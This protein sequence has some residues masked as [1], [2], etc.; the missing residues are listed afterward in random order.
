[1]KRK[2]NMLNPKLIIASLIIFIPIAFLLN[3]FNSSI[4]AQDR[5]H[6]I[7]LIHDANTNAD[8]SHIDVTNVTDMSKIFYNS[9]FNGYIA[10]WDVSSVTNM[11]EM[12]YNSKFNGDISNWDVSSVTNMSEMFYNSSF[13]GDISNSTIGAWVTNM[14]RMFYRARAKFNSDISNW[15]VSSVTDMSVMF[16]SSKFNGDISN[17]DVSSVTDMS[18]MFGSSKFNGDISNWNVSSVTN[19]SHMFNRSEFNGNLSNWDVSSVTDMSAMF[20]SSKFNGDISNWVVNNITFKI[21]LKAELNRLGNNANLNHI[22]V[23]NITDMSR[24]FLSSKFN[25][26]ISNWDVSSVTNMSAMFSSSKFN[27]DIYN[28]NVSSVTNMSNMFNRSEFNGIPCNWRSSETINTDKMFSNSPLE[29]YGIYAKYIGHGTLCIFDFS[30]ADK[31]IYNPSNQSIQNKE[32]KKHY[33]KLISD[34][35]WYKQ[36]KGRSWPGPGQM[37]YSWLE[38]FNHLR[39]ML[40]NMRNNKFSKKNAC[41][42]LP[43]FRLVGGLSPWIFHTNYYRDK[44]AKENY[45]KIKATCKHR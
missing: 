31:E 19:M 5:D 39:D 44:S 40:I 26:D 8:L 17:W 14:S 37:S 36:Y 43:E 28:W 34:Y 29:E 12:F 35:W 6:L 38:L 33:A 15:N 3:A 16:G 21:I 30:D 41:D 1:M 11:S 20:G 45:K 25:G 2:F 23:S 22:D 10:N 27:G 24:M 9:N 42:T 32:W 13:N 4:V 7:K 18:A